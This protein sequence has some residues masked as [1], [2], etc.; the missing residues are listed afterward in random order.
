M[1][2]I[3]L[4]KAWQAIANTNVSLF[5]TG[6]AGTGKT[7]FLRRLREQLPKRVVVCASTG[8]AAINAQG[9]TLHSMFQLPFAPYI[10]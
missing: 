2:N 4:N 9:V 7:T 8:I 10:P 3:E 1:Q 5:L 6:K